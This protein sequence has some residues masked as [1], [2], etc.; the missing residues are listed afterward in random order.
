MHGMRI[1]PYIYQSIKILAA[2]AVLHP[3]DQAWAMST[4][5]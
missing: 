1:V 5:A 4:L 2:F 3:S